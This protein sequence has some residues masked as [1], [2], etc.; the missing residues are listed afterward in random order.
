MENEPGITF[1]RRL[2]AWGCGNGNIYF[3]G[4]S[5][6]ATWNTFSSRYNVPSIW[7]YDSAYNNPPAGNPD[8]P[9]WRSYY[10]LHGN[11]ADDNGRF[12]NMAVDS[13]DNIIAVGYFNKL[14]S[15]TS[16]RDWIVDKYDSSGNRA[17][18]FPLSLN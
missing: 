12:E 14:S 6:A 4:M 13:A 8:S 1:D 18:G 9:L 3:V 16:G 17:T 15:S 5:Y 10:T 2:S 11:R 7:K